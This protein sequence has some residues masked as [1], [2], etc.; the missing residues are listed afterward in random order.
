MRDNRLARAVGKYVEDMRMRGL[1][2]AYIQESRGVLKRFTLFCIEHQ[3]RCPS[4]ISPGVLRGFMDKHREYAAKT[5]AFYLTIL[6]G[7]LRFIN[8]PLA[9]KFRYRIVGRG[10]QV[11]WLSL[12]DVDKV[13]STP[14]TPLEA[15]AVG[16]HFLAGM[17]RIEVRRM[18]IWDVKEGVRTGQV[19]LIGKGSKLRTIWLHPDL[20]EIF[21]VYAGTTDSSTKAKAVPLSQTQYTTLIHRVSDR[22]G[23]PFSSHDGRRSL[24][25]N[26]WRLGA[27]MATLSALAGHSDSKTTEAYINADVD[28]IREAIEMYRPQITVQ[29]VSNPDR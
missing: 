2:E 1:G 8:S 10:R 5:Q 20:R 11:R 12:E 15:I 22:S 4:A 23:I 24:L 14:M 19:T 29:M 13:L 9:W 26:L 27:N 16:C 21:R 25:K 17:R 7:F 28:D 18:T 6:R 3:I